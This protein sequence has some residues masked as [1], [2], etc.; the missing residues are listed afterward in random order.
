MAGGGPSN[1]AQSRIGECGPG[2]GY[3]AF[4]TP[5][6]PGGTPDLIC[7]WILDFGFSSFAC[8]LARDRL[9]GR[10][11][12]F[13]ARTPLLFSLQLSRHEC[14]GFNGPLKSIH[15]LASMAVWRLVTGRTMKESKCGNNNGMRML[16][17]PIL[18][19]I[20]PASPSRLGLKYI[21]S[22]H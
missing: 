11:H 5:T 17:H 19:F 16:V 1:N 20:H 18:M 22:D 14:I 7:F 21:S 10:R 15:V 8:F 3:T 12:G 13:L 2:W 4:S 9:L 6:S